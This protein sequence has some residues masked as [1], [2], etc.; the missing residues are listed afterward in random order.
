MW[1]NYTSSSCKFPIAYMC[2]KLCKLAGSRQ[3]YSKNKKGA[4]F[5]ETQCTTITTT[6]QPLLLLPQLLQ[7]ILLV[8]LLVLQL[9][10]ILTTALLTTYYHYNIA[11]GDH[12]TCTGN[13]LTIFRPL[14]LLR[15]LPM[16]YALLSLIHYTTKD[17][18]CSKPGLEKT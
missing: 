5:F 11:Q 4:R 17:W 8:L 12:S 9:L 3:S 7:L 14:T 13:S 16:L 2:Q 1:A 10:Q 6:V 18:C 15:V